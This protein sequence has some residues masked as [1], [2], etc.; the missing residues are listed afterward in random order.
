MAKKITKASD[1]KNGGRDSI[2]RTRAA[3]E[4]A[5]VERRTMS[6]GEPGDRVSASRR[7]LI[8]ARQRDGLFSPASVRQ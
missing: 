3:E 8:E 4:D 2:L 7:R 5:L 1:K 6:Y